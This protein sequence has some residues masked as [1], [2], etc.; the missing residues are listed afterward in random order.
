MKLFTSLINTIKEHFRLKLIICF[1]LCAI[2]PLLILGTISYKISYNNIAK[3]KILKETAISCEKNQHLLEN[4]MTQIENLEDSI[5]FNLCMLCTTAEQPMS[6]YLDKLSAVRNNIASITDSFNIYHV[7]IFLPDDSFA[8][9]EGLTFC[10]L[11]DLKKYK[12]QLSDFSKQGLTPNWIFR[13][14]INFPYMVSKGEEPSGVLSCYRYAKINSQKTCLAV[15][16]TSEELSNYLNTFS[17]GN[18][19]LSYIINSE[20]VVLSSTDKKQIGGSLSNEKLHAITQNL[21]LSHFSYDKCEI[22]STPVHNQLFLVTETPD[23]YIRQSSSFL[24]KMIFIC[25]MIIVPLTMLSIIWVAD[26]MTN[27]INHLSH[28]MSE[29]KMDDVIDSTQIDKLVPSSST[30]LDEIDSLTVTCANML[31]ELNSSF[32]NNLQLKIQEE[33]LNYQLLQS[34]INPHFLYNILASVQNL[35]S[36]GEITKANKMLADLSLFYKGLLRTSND[37]I[38]I[39]KE[40]EIAQLYMEM[41]ALCKDNLFDWNIDME[42]GIENF[43]ICKFTLQPILENS[44]QHGFK[45]NGIHMH[46]DISIRYDDDMIEIMISDNGIG[47][48][49]EKLNELREGIVSKQIHYEKHFGISNINSRICSSLQGHG[50]LRV[51]SNKDTGTTIYIRIPQLLEDY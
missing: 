11:S 16:I 49:P 29:I 42:E 34:Q 2:L 13:K 46:I 51:E 18:P 37:L 38:P 44:I 33:K 32:E 8:S 28:S 17:E 1:I 4:R 43:L 48:S 9:K 25:F 14:D 7:N 30:H 50:T 3:D 10:S 20:G 39:K 40:L 5:H 45:G 47:M 6:N 35:L 27:K 22:I 41:E 21:R 19:S 31:S 23:Y 36:F 15:H 26:Q 24:V 12:V